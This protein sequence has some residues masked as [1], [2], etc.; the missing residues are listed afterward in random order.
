MLQHYFI[1]YHNIFCYGKKENKLNKSVKGR[2]VTAMI[3]IEYIPARFQQ[4]VEHDPKV[5][6]LGHSI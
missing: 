1:F 3:V 4:P 2:F 5:T 6:I